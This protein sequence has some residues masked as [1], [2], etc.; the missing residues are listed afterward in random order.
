M[1]TQSTSVFYDA[2]NKTNIAGD[3]VS[4]FVVFAVT[5]FGG[6]FYAIVV[7]VI[8]IIYF[9]FIA[10]ISLGL[11]LWVMIR[12]LVRFTHNRSR[13]SQ[14]I[15]VIVAG[16]LANYFQWTCYVVFLVNDG[17]PTFGEYLSATGWIFSPG[18]FVYAVGLINEAGPWSVFGVTAKG[19]TLTGIW[20]AEALIIFIVP[21]LTVWRA[22]TYPYSENLEKWYPKFTLDRDFETVVHH[23]LVP[24]LSADSLAALQRLGKGGALRHTKI[25]L[26]YTPNETYQYLTAEI[27]STESQTGYKSG[28]NVVNNFRIT[29]HEAEMILAN[30]SHQR[31]RLD[32]L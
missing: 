4:W 21:V 20:L 3:I 25:H 2:S 1:Q 28:S 13:K 11:L 5:L 7:S 24:A 10:T 32:L 15:L 12:V 16:V 31:R 29:R 27:V 23:L 9:N 17:L 14:L 18:D 19:W 30:F 6:Y 26:Y 8:P 22:N